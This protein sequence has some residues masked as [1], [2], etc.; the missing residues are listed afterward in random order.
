MRS[1]F[2]VFWFALAYPVSL[3]LAV[4]V[5][6]WFA[7]VHYRRRGRIWKPSGIES[8][9]ITIFGLLLSFT[10]L[11]SNNSLK[12]RTALIHESSDAVGELYRESQL[13]PVT[14]AAV[15]HL[16]Q[17]FLALELTEHRPRP[18]HNPA[19]IRQLENLYRRAWGQLASGQGSQPPPVE[20]LRRLLPAFSRLNA[21]TSRL[22]YSNQ[23]GTPTSIIML[24]LLSSWAIGVLVGFTNNAQETRH[25]FVPVLF[26]VI[27]VLTI[28]TIRD[29]DN[30]TLGFIRPSYGNLQDLQRFIGPDQPPA[31]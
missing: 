6:Y 13:L 2:E 12:E 24:L 11:S 18:A 4:A 31:R 5:G 26:I 19:H 3:V 30:P 17:Q 25:Y 27:S 20:E 22:H 29:L 15:R 14:G 23:E 16:L 8:A 1:F 21:A 7:E 10:L 28:Q 9:L